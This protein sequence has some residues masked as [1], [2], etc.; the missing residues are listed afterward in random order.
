MRGGGDGCPSWIPG[1][2]PDSDRFAGTS[3]GRGPR[4]PVGATTGGIAA[5]GPCGDAPSGCCLGLGSLFSP[6]GSGAAWAGS[7]GRGVCCR[8]WGECR[9][10]EV[11]PHVR[12]AIAR[13]VRLKRHITCPVPSL[14]AAD[15][16]LRRSGLRY[17]TE[18]PHLRSP[19]SYT[20]VVV[21]DP[22]CG[23]PSLTAPASS[24]KVRREVFGRWGRQI[25]GTALLRD[26]GLVHQ[27]WPDT[28]AP[29]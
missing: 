11:S 20:P 18:M 3:G 21:P 15:S 22:S 26:R 8:V 5:R 28:D 24:G 13:Q 19:R 12:R 17:H 7:G 9:A 27:N 10:P 4:T 16:F 2:T 1:W 25:G 6:R 29:E 14:L 23:L